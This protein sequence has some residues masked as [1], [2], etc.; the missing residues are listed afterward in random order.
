MVSRFEWRF[1]D[2]SCERD[3][4]LFLDLIANLLFRQVVPK[5]L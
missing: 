1:I 5:R 2:E 4:E 3:R